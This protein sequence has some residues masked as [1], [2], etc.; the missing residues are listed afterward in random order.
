M[1]QEIDLL[2]N[3]PKTKRNIEERGAEKTEEHRR[4]A[5]RFDR[6]FFDGDRAVGYGGYNYSPRFWGPTIP[7]FINF[8]N[9]SDESSLLD[10][11][12][13]KGFMLYDFR[14]ALPKA[15]LKGVDISSYAIEHTVEAMKKDVSVASA[16]SLPFPDKSF[17]LVISINTI[18][19]LPLSEL[20]I[21]LREIMRV[22]RRDAFITVDAY[23]NDEEKDRMLKWNLTAQTILHVE[24]W[25]QVF[26]E[27]GYRGDYYWFIP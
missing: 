3:Y 21:A 22:S 10:V 4:I 25:K 23:R 6:D 16:V 20:K 7:D 18:H 5:R 11:G 19:N 1:Q 26:H 2:R 15:I 12:S 27:C 9:L 8:Y 17:D 24:E 14:Q 13:G